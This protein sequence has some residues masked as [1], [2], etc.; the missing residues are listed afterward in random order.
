MKRRDILTWGAV[1]DR[2][3]EDWRTAPPADARLDRNAPPP[4]VRSLSRSLPRSLPRV[5]P[6]PPP[7]PSPPPL[8][9]LRGL[10]GI[11]A[12]LPLLFDVADGAP[13][14]LNDD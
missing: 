5:Q 2:T 4:L 6:P 8:A 3:S 10:L 9:A 11:A 7:P 12:L 14:L 1:L 13:E